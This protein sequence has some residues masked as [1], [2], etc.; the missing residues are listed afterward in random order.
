MGLLNLQGTESVQPEM[1]GNMEVL[2]SGNLLNS[3]LDIEAEIAKAK[4]GSKNLLRD[5]I[6]AAHE[7]RKGTRATSDTDT[8]QM[9][10]VPFPT[11]STCSR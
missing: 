5:A 8:E 6:Q 4:K 3:T 11:I 1:I 10:V 9:Y 2:P 7:A